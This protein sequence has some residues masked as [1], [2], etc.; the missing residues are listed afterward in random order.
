MILPGHK[1]IFASSDVD[2]LTDYD[3]AGKLAQKIAS[4]LLRH[5]QEEKSG[6]L[7]FAPNGLSLFILFSW[8][9]WIPVLV[10][11]EFAKIFISIISSERSRNRKADRLGMRLMDKAGFDT[12]GAI[13]AW[14]KTVGLD[15]Q[16]REKL[17]PIEIW[18]SF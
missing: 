14:E 9:W 2:M 4:V 6:Q 11:F 18:S 12:F 13:S 10:E 5:I 3:V 16:V 17:F 15:S 1:S 7:F 8:K